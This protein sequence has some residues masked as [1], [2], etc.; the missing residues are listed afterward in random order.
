MLRID[1]ICVKKEEN[2]RVALSDVR[3]CI[4]NVMQKNASSINFIV[5][6]EDNQIKVILERSISFQTLNKILKAFDNK[7]M[8]LMKLTL[9]RKMVGIFRRGHLEIII[10]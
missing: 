3:Q 1:E 6:E 2:S 10:S 7:R 5:T 4:E 8:K 9:E